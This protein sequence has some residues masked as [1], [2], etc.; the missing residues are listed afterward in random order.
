ME[1]WRP[2][3]GYEDRYLVSD[4]GQVRSLPGKHKGRILKK[5]IGTHGREYV[6]LSRLGK[7]QKRFVHHLVLEA[8]IGPRSE[9]TECCHYDGNPINN[10]LSNLRWDTPANNAKDK[11]RHGT[12]SVPEYSRQ[13]EKHP[14]SKLTADDV[15]KIRAQ[16]AAGDACT[17][18]AE[19]YRVSR[20]AI[21]DIKRRK[22]WNKNL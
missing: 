15:G 20:S 6:S 7:V 10:V 16:L 17:D 9:G 2:V 14:S 8:F 19:K 4:L 1:S 11:L 21:S 3:P 13:G 18:I 22:T 5:Q 12:H